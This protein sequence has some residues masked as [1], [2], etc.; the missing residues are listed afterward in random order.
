MT[1]AL[2]KEG[3]GY[4]YTYGKGVNGRLG[5]GLQITR[6]EESK[7]TPTKVVTLG[8]FSVVEIYCGKDANGAFDH[9]STP[10]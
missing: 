7:L 6:S 10:I 3:D 2:S 9:S 5:H 4:L 8:Q 1:L